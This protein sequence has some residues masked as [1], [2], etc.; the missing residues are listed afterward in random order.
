[1]RPAEPPFGSRFDGFGIPVPWTWIDNPIEQLAQL[2]FSTVAMAL[3]KQSVTIDSPL[4]QAL[5]RLA[6]IMGTEGDGLPRNVVEA[7]D[8]G[9]NT[10]AARR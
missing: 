6:I 4:L 9:K 10:H 3:T 7:A 5:S 2:G 1:M 8:Y